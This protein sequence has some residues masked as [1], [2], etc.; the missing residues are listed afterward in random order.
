[1]GHECRTLADAASLLDRRPTLKMRSLCSEECSEE[2][3]WLGGYD[4]YNA[5][6]LDGSHALDHLGNEELDREHPKHANQDRGKQVRR[7]NLRVIC[8]SCMY[9]IA[10]AV[11]GGWI[12]MSNSTKAPIPSAGLHLL[13]LTGQIQENARRRGRRT[14]NSVSVKTSVKP[15]MVASGGE[16][17]RARHRGAQRGHQRRQ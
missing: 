9:W 1:M 8:R 2:H 6:A 13:Y 14:S 3:L 7:A 17:P 4:G 10:H 15:N 16:E 12:F 5:L 11:A